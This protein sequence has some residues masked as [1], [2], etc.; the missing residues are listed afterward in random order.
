MTSDC[1]VTIVEVKP[2]EELK[3][4]ENKGKMYN[5]EQGKH[6]PYVY[7]MQFGHGNPIKIG[8]SRNLGAR[9]R[10]IQ[11]SHFEPLTMLVVKLG[12]RKDEMPLHDKFAKYQVRGEWFSASDEVLAFARE[13]ESAELID[14]LRASIELAKNADEDEVLDA[15]E[16]QKWIGKK[17]ART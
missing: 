7:F 9:L 17:S 8:Y 11:A 5:Y 15:C 1:C 6:D 16:R 13:L 12:S 10:L 3:T 4:A 2:C 14:K